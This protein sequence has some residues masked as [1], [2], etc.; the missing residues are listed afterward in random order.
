MKYCPVAAPELYLYDPSQ[1]IEFFGNEH[2]EWAWFIPIGHVFKF[3]PDLPK[4]GRISE[5][6]IALQNYWAFSKNYIGTY[7]FFV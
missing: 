5:V 1:L 7:K 6:K 2:P 4:C 3:I